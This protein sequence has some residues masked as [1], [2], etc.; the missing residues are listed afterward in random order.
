[1]TQEQIEKSKVIARYM[2]KE[3]KVLNSKL[4]FQNHLHLTGTMYHV[5]WDAL[6]EVYDKIKSTLHHEDMDLLVLQTYF[7]SN[8]KE[9]IFNAIYNFLKNK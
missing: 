4:Y 3:T 6:H 7:A 9:E 8:T 2:G 5:S 1:M